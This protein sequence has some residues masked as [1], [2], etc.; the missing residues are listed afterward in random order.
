VRRLVAVVLLVFVGAVTASAQIIPTRPGTRPTQPV[1]RRDS[2]P[3]DSLSIVKWPDPD[4]TVQ[5]LLQRSGYTVTRYQG[6]TAYFNAQQKSL[7]LLA[8]K[9]HRAIVTRDSQT[10]ISDKRIYYTEAKRNVVV[11]GHYILRD[12]TSGQADITGDTQGEYNLADRSATVRNARFAVSEGD[13]WYLSSKQATVVVDSLDAASTRLYA[14]GGTMTS[15]PDSIP[16]YHFE[17]GEAK[18]V[19]NILA[20]RPAILYIKDVPVMWLPFLFSDQRQGRHS[21]ILPPRFGIGDIVRNSPSYRRN[22]ENFGYYFVPNEYMDVSAWLDWRSRAG[23]EANDPGWLRYN[24]EWNYKW[25]DRFLGGR[26]GLGY[27]MQGATQNFAASWNHQQEFSANSRFNASLNYVTNTT[28]QRQNT[29]N[30]YTAMATIASQASYQT[31]IGPASIS[32]GGTRKQYPGRVQVDQTFPTVNLTTTPIK[33]GDWLTWTPTFSASRSDTKDMDQPGIGAFLYVP[34]GNTFPDSVRATGRNSAQSSVTFDT[35]IQIFGRDFKNSFRV[36]Q[37]RN[38]FPQQ[39]ALYD[40]ETGAV[41]ENRV[42]A[43]TYRTDVDWTPD[44]TLPPFWRNKF[45]F[46]PS[47]SLQNVDPGPF[48]VAS[49]RT[50]GGYVHQ[51]KRVT[52]SASAS[53]TLFGLFPGMGPFSRFRHS[54]APSLGYSWAPK[55]TVSDEYLI[56][57]GRTRAGYL[58]GIRQ[59]AVTLGLQQ[60]VEAKVR[61][62]GDTA[63][64]ETG[65]VIRLISINM[66][67]IS[68]DFERARQ[69]ESNSKFAGF[70]SPNWGYNLSSELLPGFDFSTTYSLFQGDPISDTAKFAPV[71]TAV[72]A[73]FSFG[74][75]Q[76]PFAVLAKLFGKAVPEVQPTPVPGT[77]E[78]RPRPDAPQMQMIGAQPVAGDMRGGDR[79]I[80][81]PTSGW[82]AQFSF[83]RSSPRQPVGDS[84]SIIDYDPRARCAQIAGA[85][86]FVFQACL[87]QQ[88]AQPT[89]E[90]PIEKTTAG[91]PSYRIPATTS[92]NGNIA[93]NLTPKWATTWQTTYDFERHEFASHIVS[94]QRDLHD[95]RAIFGFTQSPNGNFAFHFTI[96][97][98]AEPDIKFDYNKSTVRTTPSF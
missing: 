46:A 11:L 61:P 50:N 42:F 30:T 97:L 58:G 6:D 8:S 79:F 59:N 12:P 47:I 33:I 57:L 73:S 41:V 36:S 64:A 71:L 53:P 85:D 51:T 54:F 27:T 40:L 35:P 75:D 28:M 92:L 9:D 90:L 55:A 70:S 82:R 89:N 34:S 21:G 67:P 69:S 45:N 3:P 37:Q 14:R 48:W 98:K 96:A 76:N 86:E 88:A 26:V 74:R 43:A 13:M 4:S 94:L 7:D 25:I 72:S 24:A 32:V 84:A 29:F 80:T 95:W 16:D 83:S 44:F 22:I 31:K 10:V 2:T 91:G 15:C 60:N 65:Q 77:T 87:A 93:F 81:P 78:V 56:A 19:G 23:G 1:V 17:F 5:A 52:L 62:K 49:E 39:V 63:S 38:N 68:Y 20:A 18:R 66:T